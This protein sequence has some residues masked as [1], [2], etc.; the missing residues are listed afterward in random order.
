MKHT[1]PHHCKKCPTR[2]AERRD[3]DR[4][5]WAWHPK[6]AARLGLPRPEQPGCSLCAKTFTRK[7]N[8]TR[9]V[10]NCHADGKRGR[11]GDRA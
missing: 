11:S 5:Y 8:L 10:R 3:L 1:R 6:F 2:T 9:H 4:H 7:D